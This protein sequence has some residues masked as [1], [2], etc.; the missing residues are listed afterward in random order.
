MPSV[1]LARLYTGDSWA[2]IGQA[3]L[4]MRAP[5]EKFVIEKGRVEHVIA[6][7]E[8][9]RA[10]HYICALPFERLSSSVIPRICLSI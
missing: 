1:P 3:D 6:G 8:Q 7:G 9:L 5:I 10:D 2:R 4:R